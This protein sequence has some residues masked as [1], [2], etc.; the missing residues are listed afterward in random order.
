M[1]RGARP[2]KADRPPRVGLGLLGRAGIAALLI[3]VATAGAVSATV[4]LDV[5][6]VR[7]EFLGTG[8]GRAQIEIPEITKADAG[9]ARTIMVLGSDARYGDKKL[10]VK[11]RSDTIVLVR[12]DPDRDA[13]AVMSIPRD[14]KVQIPGYPYDDKINAA[15]SNGG[16]RLTFKTV[17][18]LFGLATGKNFPINNVINVDFAGF[19]RAINFIG[20]VYVDLDRRYFNDNTSGEL[21]AT[22]DVQPGYQKLKG[23][24]A[25][26]YVRYRHTDNDFIRAARQQDFLRE[27]RSQAGFRKLLD[28]EKRHE[29]ARAFGR[30]F[31]VDKSLNSTKEIFSLLKLAIYAAREV[32]EIQQVKFH[33]SEDGDYVIASNKQLAKTV[34]EFMH[35]KAAAPVSSS[36]S[37]KS[38]G[39]KRRKGRKR[40]TSYADVPNIDPA[41][42]EGEN[43]A[44][45]AAN[46]LGF[47]FYFPTRKVRASTYQSNEP[48]IYTIKDEKGKKHRAYRLV[49][50][51]PGIGEYYGV[52]GMTW[53][54][55]PM[56]DSPSET[57]TVNGRKLQ[58][59]YDRRRLRLVAWKTPRAVYWISNTLTES[60]SSRQML[61]I[62]S[63]LSRTR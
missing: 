22:I 32:K 4:I 45:L 62:A 31:Q 28:L 44:I 41:R 46:R 35:A 27:A 38:S 40:K 39:S 29:L 55:P 23:Q 25:L 36:G 61:A 63:S 33:A 53:K 56:L 11:P 59:Y 47:P 30:Y 6:Q 51:K 24:D 43:Q 1:R 5:D 20:G 52:Q 2:A 18:R 16:A 21:Y 54:D 14:L 9:G 42:T 60:L 37:K 7:K 8:E 58:L 15:Y 13:V 50:K 3:V 19:R 49:V 34:D 10:G 17:K 48:R 12:V 57:R 26:D